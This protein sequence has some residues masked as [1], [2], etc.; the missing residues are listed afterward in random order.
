MKLKIF[1]ATPEA[2][3]SE[4]LSTLRILIVCGVV[5]KENDRTF[6]GAFPKK[7]CEAGSGGVC[8]TGDVLIAALLRNIVGGDDT[9]A[10]RR[11]NR[12]TIISS[13]PVRTP[14]SIAASPSYPAPDLGLPS[15][16]N[17]RSVAALG[18]CPDGVG[19]PPKFLKAQDLR[20]PSKCCCIILNFRVGY[21]PAPVSFRGHVHSKTSPQ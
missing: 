15:D 18:A 17:G 10:T 5:A 2:S 12:T 21:L 8:C 3:R 13:S 9:A 7:D 14:R 16:P 20:T 19:G 6:P 1:G 4:K 11:S